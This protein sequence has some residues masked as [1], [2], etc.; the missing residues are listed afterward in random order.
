MADEDRLDDLEDILEEPSFDDMK[1]EK[2]DLDTRLSK[3][4]S[5]VR[6]I[7]DLFKTRKRVLALFIGVILFILIVAGVFL[8]FIGN[9]KDTDE[10]SRNMA[11]SVDA[12]GTMVSSGRVDQI[13]FEDIVELEPFQGIRLK[14]SSTMGLISLGL[15]LE[16]T[17]SQDRNQI[18]LKEDRIRDIII[19]QAS[20][21][22]WLELRNPDGKIRLKYE[23]LKRINSLYPKTTVRN[24]YFTY[25]LMQ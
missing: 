19:T 14:D 11:E 21:M 22:T 16:L 2:G 17:D 6:F 18:Q 7:T 10:Q 5:P 24:I 13:I 3:K 9:D 20:E 8:F 12:S 15:A 4:K 25:F 23:L 1:S